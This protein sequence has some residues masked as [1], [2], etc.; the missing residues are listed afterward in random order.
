ML[1]SCVTSDPWRQIWAAISLW[2]R[3]LAE[4][5]GIFWPVEKK[6][7][8]NYRICHWTS[9]FKSKILTSGDW[10]HHIN[11][12]NS[13]LNHFFWVDSGIGVNG[14]TLNG[15]KFLDSIFVLKVGIFIY[16]I[17]LDV[18]KIFSHYCWSFIY[19]FSGAVE[20]STQHVFWNGCS[21]DVSG[22]FTG[23]FFGIDSRCS[24]KNLKCIRCLLKKST[25][26][27]NEDQRKKIN[28]TLCWEAFLFTYSG[29]SILESPSYTV[30][31]RER[32]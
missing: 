17:Y 16:Y 12:T 6:S 26:R 25:S 31:I 28:L 32:F 3:P 30:S 22:K 2:G 1:P 11:G 9:F 5:I 19:G 10:I 23:G 7:W 8:W 13:G 21:Q 24:F 15:K 14:L 18:Q 4:K 29:P 20:N 27:L